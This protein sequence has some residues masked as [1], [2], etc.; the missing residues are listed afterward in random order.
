MSSFGYRPFPERSISF[1]ASKAIRL[2]T[3]VVPAS[4]A[5]GPVQQPAEKEIR[6]QGNDAMFRPIVILRLEESNTALDPESIC[7]SFWTESPHTLTF[8]YVV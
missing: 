7:L 6:F 5:S 2:V 4:A 8:S 1:L 3:R